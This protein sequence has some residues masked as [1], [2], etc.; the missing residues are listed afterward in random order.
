MPVFRFLLTNPSIF[1]VAEEE[2]D[3]WSLWFDATIERPERD[4]H[5]YRD[6]FT[7]MCGGKEYN[8][9]R[10][11]GTIGIDLHQS[12][13]RKED[14][15]EHQTK[16]GYIRI[17]YFPPTEEFPEDVPPKFEIRTSLLPD[18]F[19][20]LLQAN[21]ENCLIKLSVHTR[22]LWD[23]DQ[24]TQQKEGLVYG[25]DPNG[26]DYIWHTEKKWTSCLDLVTLTMTPR[27][28]TKEVSESEPSQQ[29]IPPA[30]PAPTSRDV[31]TQ[32][33]VSVVNRLF[34]AVVIVGLFLVL[35]GL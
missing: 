32:K 8:G 35:R 6:S 1:L 28:Q 24:E 30:F 3:K 18:T 12:T 23:K 17:N 22:S 25:D 5:G 10:L 13:E 9:F 21:P 27:A 33:L 2:S 16:L 11:T 31:D 7:V 34:W 26:K 20:R 14:E 29:T 15:A 4:Y 19:F